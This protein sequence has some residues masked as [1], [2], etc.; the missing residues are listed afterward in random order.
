MEAQ[1]QN[2]NPKSLSFQK[3]N[4]KNG[5]QVKPFGLIQSQT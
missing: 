3:E 2:T 4:V 1:K 5:E